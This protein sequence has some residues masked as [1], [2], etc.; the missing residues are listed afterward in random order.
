MK[1]VSRGLLGISGECPACGAVTPLDKGLCH[2]AEGGFRLIPS[3]KC[4]C[5]HVADFAAEPYGSPAEETRLHWLE[6]IN[7]WW[8]RLGIGAVVGAILVVAYVV[9]SPGPASPASPSSSVG[10]VEAL[11]VKTEWKRAG[12]D[13]V[14][15]A[16][17]SVGNWG[18]SAA[19]DLEF[20]CTA[21]GASGTRISSLKKTVYS[22]I[23]GR[24]RTT[25]RDLNLGLIDPQ[26]KRLEGTVTGASPSA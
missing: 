2:E 21:F 17:L 25:F 13:N 26:T 8:I 24:G 4:S 3:V 20:T 10:L 5:G 16:T 9:R 19:K 22:T 14:A 23:D 1:V 6:R 11:K 18:S 12:F 15:I 7:P